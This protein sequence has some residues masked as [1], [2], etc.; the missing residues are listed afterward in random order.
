MRTDT[1]PVRTPLIGRHNIYN[2]LQAAAV[3]LHYGIEL[4]TIVRGLE[5][6]ARVP[7]RLERIE[8]G[9]PF[10]VY[11]DYAHTADALSECLKAVR[12]VTHGRLICVFG[13]G[14]DRDAMKRPK[15][16]RTVSRQAD[17]AVLTSDNPRTEDPQAIV[18][19]ILAG[20]PQRSQ[21]KVIRDR[22]AAI[23]WALSE[24]RK[25]DAVLI[26]GKGHEDYQIIGQERIE[27]D[28]REVAREWL[29]D[30]KI[31]D[32]PYR[33]NMSLYPS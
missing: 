17:V 18:D 4:P 20:F 28:D 2:C 30:G 21:A 3:G 29:Y 13:A 5:S 25:G 7:G 22:G 6:V 31:T 11:V 9:Q 1:I 14:G 12:D 15:M 27:F 8:C 24:A 10:G 23:Q 19:G 16:G 32:E 33:G 26:A